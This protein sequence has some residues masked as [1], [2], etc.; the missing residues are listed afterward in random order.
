MHRCLLKYHHHD[1]NGSFYKL[2]LTL[3]DKTRILLAGCQMFKVNH[4]AYWK[5]K[6]S[7]KCVKSKTVLKFSSLY[8]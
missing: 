5:T 1:T 8:V 4:E 6:I 2:C 3:R 7:R